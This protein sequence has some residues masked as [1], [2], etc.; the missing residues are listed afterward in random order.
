[1]NRK[2]KTATLSIASNSLL[3]LMKLVVGVISGSVSIISEAI[4]SSMDLAAAIIAF[5]SV[6]ISDK[7]AD[8]DHPYGHDKI[9]NVSGVIE[10]VLIFIAAGWIIYEAVKKMFG[11]VEKVK[12]ELVFLGFIVMAI[13]AV[14]NF[15]VA[16]KLYKVAKEEHSIALEAD[17]LHLKA[18]VY[19]SVGVS[20]GLLLIW[21]FP[22]IHWLDPIVAIGVAIFILR[23]AFELLHEAFQPLLDAKLDDE[24]IEVVKNVILKQNGVACDFHEL[25]TRK[26]GKTKHIDLHLTMPQNMSVKE[27]HDICD[28]IED[29]IEKELKNTQVL[30]HTEPCARH[31]EECANKDKKL[32]YCSREI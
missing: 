32:I 30:I 10:A 7:P 2:E 6:R 11:D 13:S 5:L 31:C 25:R 16:K 14:V 3:I 19:T 26:S 4:H 24:S 28:I 18:D 20:V 21:I 29:E 22:T 9:E 17:A 8:E 15:F 27:A 1:M 23:E 12:S